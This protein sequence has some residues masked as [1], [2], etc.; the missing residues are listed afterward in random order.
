MSNQVLELGTLSFPNKTIESTVNE[1]LSW[2]TIDVQIMVMG[3]VDTFL[4]N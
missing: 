2:Q 1:I 3:G 4:F